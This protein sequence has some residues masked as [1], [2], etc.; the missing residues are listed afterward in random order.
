[1]GKIITLVFG[2]AILFAG[3]IALF[4]TVPKLWHGWQERAKRK[5]ELNKKRIAFERSH[6][7]LTLILYDPKVSALV[8][9]G[10]KKHAK[11]LRFKELTDDEIA[12]MAAMDAEVDET[13]FLDA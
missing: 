11:Q 13:L 6:D 10:L 3:L 12:E 2:L 8:Y 7:L 4:K 1:M 5:H 9:A